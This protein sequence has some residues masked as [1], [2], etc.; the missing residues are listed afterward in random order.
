MC[1]LI[2]KKRDQIGCYA[3]RTKHGKKLV[4]LKR[5]LNSAVLDS[6]VQLVTISRPI[7]Y[8][9]Y[10]PYKFIDNKDEFT[11]AVLSLK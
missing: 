1:Y 6:K 5:E 3:Y 9:E 7:A 2:A 4:E 10:K 8:G 11:K